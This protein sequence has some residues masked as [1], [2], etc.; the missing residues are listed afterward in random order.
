MCPAKFSRASVPFLRWRVLGVPLACR[1][2]CL[3]PDVNAPFSNANVACEEV[4][5][6]DSE[7]DFV[8]L[9]TFLSLQK[10]QVFCVESQG[11]LNFEGALVK[12]PPATRRKATLRTPLQSPPPPPGG[13]PMRIWPA[14]PQDR[15]CD[16]APV[17]APPAS[18]RKIMPPTP[19][20]NPQPPVESTPRR[21]EV[22]DQCGVEYGG[23][24]RWT[25]RDRAVTARTEQYLNESDSVEV[26]I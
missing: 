26:E 9:Q 2:V 6:S 21:R 24:H 10:C 5:S 20:Q 13:T 22:E 25:A 11:N 1:C 19:Q 16:G 18:R 14:W 7:C 23:E 8:E 3:L 4:V 15:N 12:A 17:T